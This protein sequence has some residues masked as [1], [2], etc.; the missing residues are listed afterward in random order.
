MFE[1]VLRLQTVNNRT[2]FHINHVNCFLDGHVNAM[3]A[4][5]VP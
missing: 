5:E 4:E 1:F 3:G 2:L